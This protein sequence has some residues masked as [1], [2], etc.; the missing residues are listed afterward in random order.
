MGKYGFKDDKSKSILTDLFRVEH[1]QK[2]G[3]NIVAGDDVEI[4]VTVPQEVIDGGYELLGICRWGATYNYL[5][6][7][8]VTGSV[9]SGTIKVCFRDTKDE[10]SAGSMNVTVKFCLAFIRGGYIRTIS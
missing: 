4:N 3:L 6:P 8:S 2:T 9:S 5:V 1:F 10:G 7:A